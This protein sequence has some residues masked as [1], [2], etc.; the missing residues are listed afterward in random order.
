MTTFSQVILAPTPTADEHFGNTV[1]Q[2]G[3]WLAAT[4]CP[5]NYVAGS[6]DSVVYLYKHNGTQ[7]VYHSTLPLVDAFTNR[8]SKLVVRISPDQ[9]KMAVGSNQANGMLGRVYL[10]DY[11][12]GTDT[13]APSAVTPTIVSPSIVNWAAE[14]YGFGSLLWNFGTDIALTNELLLV[15]QNPGGGWFGKAY[16]YYLRD[17]GWWEFEADVTPVIGGK[18][19]KRSY[20]GSSL[21][22]DESSL[23][24][25]AV[26]IA[27]ARKGEHGYYWSYGT[28]YM[29]TRTGVDEKAWTLVDTLWEGGGHT[30]PDPGGPGDYL[31]FGAG[32]T[33]G[34]DKLVVRNEPMSYGAGIVSYFLR[35]SGA[36]TY[37]LVST[38]AYDP[39]NSG[40]ITFSD[41][42][43]DRFLWGRPGDD[44][45]KGC[46][47]EMR[48]VEDTWTI[49]DTI[50]ANPKISSGNF[51]IS[52]SQDIVAAIGAISSV[53]GGT[54]G[55]V[56]MYSVGAPPVA[57]FTSDETSGADSL[58]VQFTD[59]S[60]NTPNSWLWNFG[61]GGTSTSQNPTHTF[62]NT[63]WH[64]VSLIATNDLGNDTETKSNYIFVGKSNFTATPLSGYPNLTVQFTDTTTFMDPSSA[65]IKTWLWNFGDGT[66]S[67]SQNPTHTYTTAGKY[68]VILTTTE[69]GT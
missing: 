60:T 54:Q 37:S 31:Q 56:Y 46:V 29:W 34:S 49:A 7:F 36:E 26:R 59:I 1:A 64:T 13:W 27:I 24:T 15:S 20:Y 65:T 30:E 52:V 18:P 50:Y 67:T 23:G 14:G 45:N 63:G 4:P 58:T 32:I 28:I 17:V 22:I 61:D 25:S 68:T 8:G 48:L 35:D 11:N 51:G 16:A 69:V 6:R 33:F 2:R 9:T 41:I 43:Y 12:A 42:R 55:A 62:T 19:V 66:T 10:F 3:V 53:D 21:A 40:P 47:Y 44:S 57:D 38:S 39:V 5:T